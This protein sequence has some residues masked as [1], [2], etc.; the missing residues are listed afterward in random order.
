MK[1]KPIRLATY[2]DFPVNAL[3]RDMGEKEVVEWLE[4]DG[5]YIFWRATDIIDGLYVECCF[6]V[7]IEFVEEFFERA[8]RQF[9][10]SKLPANVRLHPYG[11]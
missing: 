7:D 2:K 8:G 4:I 9:D 5:N 1:N 11:V 10:K 6:A 3:L